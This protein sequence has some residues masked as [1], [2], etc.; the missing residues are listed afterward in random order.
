MLKHNFSSLLAFF[1]NMEN[2]NLLQ[3]TSP[4]SHTGDTMV[5]ASAISLVV[6]FTNDFQRHP[7]S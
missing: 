3:E 6:L 7:V 4:I 1:L 2:T 5:L